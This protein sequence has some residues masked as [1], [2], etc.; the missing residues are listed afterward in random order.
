MRYHNRF[1]TA[2]FK[3]NFLI[4]SAIDYTHM[5]KTASFILLIDGSIGFLKWYRTVYINIHFKKMTSVINGKF[6]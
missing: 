6:I 1:T 5:L 4:H 3:L 2:K